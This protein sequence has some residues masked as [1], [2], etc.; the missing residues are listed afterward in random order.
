ML[1]QVKQLITREPVLRYFDN[2]K[3]VTLQCDASESGLGATIMQEGQP[4]AFSSRALSNT[5]KN[6]AQIDKE[7]L[8]IVHG[9][10]RF[11]Q[12]VYGREV[13]VQT[14]HK[15]LENMFTKP[16]LSAPKRLQRMLLH[17]QKYNL[18]IAYKPGK[19][20]FIADTLS[21]AFIPN[22]QTP[23]AKI[24]DVYAVQQEEYLIRAI[25]EI[26]MVE[27]LPITTE[28]LADLREKTERN[29]S[30]QKLKHVIRVGWPDTKE[31]PPE[32]RNYFHLKEEL[33]M[34]DGILFKGNRVIVPATLRSYMLKKVR[35]SHIGVESCLRKAT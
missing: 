21:R 14:D 11:H 20:L 27:F 22:E 19:E 15:P 8:S 24:C 31:V 7:L 34:Q 9:C 5:E 33:T 26:D 6:Y 30:L 1:T 28:R 32:I 10:T 18:K 25:E 4:A 2:T 23:E 35:S 29:G 17:L 16:L 12:Y 13:T 3:E